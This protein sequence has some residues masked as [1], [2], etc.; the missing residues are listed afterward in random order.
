MVVDRLT[1]YCH[2]IALTHPYSAHE[3]A[4]EFLNQI[5]KLHGVP[6]AIITDRDPLFINSFWQEL[7][8]MLGTKLNL[9]SPY[10]PQTDGQTERV[11]QCIEMYL[12]YMTSDK[13]KEWANWIALAE[14]WYNTT[15]HTST[16]MTPYQALYNQIPPTLSYQAA[17]SKDPVVIQFAKDRIQTLRLLKENLSKSQKRM[18]VFADRRRTDREFIVGDEVFLKLQPYRQSSVAVRTNQKLAA[19]YYGPKK[20]WKGSL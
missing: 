5:V 15:F 10:H 1:K 13:P 3:V 11:N 4:Q 2:L 8:K 12:R 17:R 7:F 19:K 20:G 9:S 16:G 14:W 18:K 6:L